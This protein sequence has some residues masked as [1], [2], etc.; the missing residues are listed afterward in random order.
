MPGLVISRIAGITTCWN[1]ML[2]GAFP[3]LQ[4]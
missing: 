4:L 3:A 2:V 1:E